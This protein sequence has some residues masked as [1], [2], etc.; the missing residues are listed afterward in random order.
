[1]K[2]F[3]RG[4]ATLE[5]TFEAFNLFNS[6]VIY[7]YR[8]TSYATPAFQQPSFVLNARLVGVGLQARW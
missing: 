8:S 1:M 7:S 2:S 3:K 6:D 4:R 5:P